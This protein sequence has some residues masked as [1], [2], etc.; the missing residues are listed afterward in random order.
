MIRSDRK[1]RGEEKFW[2][3]KDGRG[4][5]ELDWVKKEQGSGK[6]SYFDNRRIILLYKQKEERPGGWRS[7]STGR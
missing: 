7:G 6:Q 5:I 2:G 1:L 3:Y 4:A